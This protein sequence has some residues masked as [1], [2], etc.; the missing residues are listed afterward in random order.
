MNNTGPLTGLKVIEVAGIGP[1]P[2]AAMVLADM[3][4]DVI[5][6]DRIGKATA[7]FDIDPERDILSRNRRSLA[8]DLKSAAGNKVVL[9]LCEHS[10]VL[11]EG[12]RPGVMERLGLGPG[13]CMQANPALVYGRVTG[14]GQTGPLAKSAGHD[15]NYIALSGCLHA[16]GR[17]HELP[18][19]PLNLVG[20]YGGGAMLLVAGVLAAVMH[21]RA[22]GRGQV[23]DAAILDG[24][25]LFTSA[26]MG[27]RNMGLWSDKRASNLLDGGAY[28]YDCYLTRDGKYLSIGSLEPKFFTELL[29]I[30]QL[31]PATFVQGDPS[32][33]PALR[34]QL[35][36][37]ILQR[38]RDEWAAIFDGTDACVA[39]VLSMAEAPGHAHNVAREVFIHRFG[40][41][42]PAPAPR[43][44]ATPSSVRLPPPRIGEHTRDILSELSFSCADIDAMLLAGACA[45]A[46]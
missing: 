2:F 29:R 41:N 32:R 1:G 20:D 13:D 44:S 38:N 26:F 30:A 19:P 33:W 45:E 27:L 34:G 40:V 11:I 22:S 25:A 14:W 21:A 17:A 8:V 10:S 4:A 35:A 5:R 39:P 42:Q 28:F 15:I 31:D 7:S 16:M 23:V 37:V 24:S 6:V 43:F 3:G 18:A 36:T 46:R 9:R 12:F